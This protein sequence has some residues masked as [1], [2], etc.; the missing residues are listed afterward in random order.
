MW[1]KNDDKGVKHLEDDTYA[2]RFTYNNIS[3]LMELAG[4][5]ECGR[6]RGGR[7]TIEN[8]VSSLI[9]SQKSFRRS[10]RILATKIYKDHRVAFYTRLYLQSER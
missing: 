2:K 7:P 10:K 3:L 8:E 1:F 4:V 6:T 9:S 5:E